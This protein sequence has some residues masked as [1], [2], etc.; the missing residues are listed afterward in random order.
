MNRIM[1]TSCVALCTMGV[2]AAAMSGASAHPKS[3][4][5]FQERNLVVTLVTPTVNQEVLSDLSDPG[6]NNVITVRFSSVINPHDF[7]DNQNVVNGLS[8]KVEFLDATFARLP[9]TPSVR[10]NVFTFSPLSSQ[11]PVLPQG[12]YTLN[13]KSSI[14]NT[15]GNLLNDGVGDF[16]TTFSVATDRYAP[17]LRRMSPIDGETGIGL[18]Q[19]VIATFNEPIDGGSILTSVLVQDA[20]TNPPT[21]IPGLGGTGLTTKRGGF[22]VVFTPDPCFGYPPKTNIQFLIQGLGTSTANVATLTDAFQNKFT[23]D[24]SLTSPSLRWTADP[25]IPTL[26]HSPNGS[27]D[28]LTGQFRSV[29]QTKG[30]RP[31]P[32]GLRPGGFMMAFPPIANPCAILLWEAPSC[33]TAGN[34]I[35]FATDS[36]VGEK[37]K[38]VGGVN[39]NAVC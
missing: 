11:V 17:V 21:N 37:K 22:D 31:P 26:F 27:Y 32:V 3:S 25:T 8:P 14:R 19:S 7:I 18:N 33:E 1:V 5:I 2:V 23:M 34:C 15:R 29:F 30:V 12:Q 38:G 39:R 9:G 13:L 36:G 28:T 4:S 24:Q 16:T 6:L 35:H 10:R 20:S